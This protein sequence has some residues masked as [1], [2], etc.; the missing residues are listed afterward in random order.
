MNLKQIFILIFFFGIT[1]EDTP[2][3]SSEFIPEVSMAGE[4]LLLTFDATSDEAL[5]ILK[6]LKVLA[7]ISLFLELLFARYQD[8]A[9]HSRIYCPWSR[10]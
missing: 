6:N 9:V 10:L 7:V 3:I 5:L 4:E 2:V 1:S 8:L